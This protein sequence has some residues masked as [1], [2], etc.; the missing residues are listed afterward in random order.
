M[1]TKFVALV[2]WYHLAF[3]LRALLN[4]IMSSAL[5]SA[6]S[7]VQKI[8]YFLPTLQK[9]CCDGKGSFKLRAASLNTVYAG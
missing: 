3:I 6:L 4:M 7:A 9:N 8:K 2:L 1:R 5:C